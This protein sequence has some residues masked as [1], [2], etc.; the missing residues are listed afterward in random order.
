MDS[1]LGE[2]LP[3]LDPAKRVEFY[4]T[5]PERIG[6]LPENITGFYELLGQAYQ[7]GSNPIPVRGA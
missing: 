1:S 2:H 5:H 6:L 3:P 4:R 7:Q